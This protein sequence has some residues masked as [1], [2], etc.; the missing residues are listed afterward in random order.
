MNGDT[1]WPPLY[2]PSWTST[3]YGAA[4]QGAIS[5]ASIYQLIL[6]KHCHLA[7]PAGDSRPLMKGPH[8][9]IKF[10]STSENI[11]QL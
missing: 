9:L 11:N 7:V 5:K 1:E 4:T 3:I 8:G 2:A 6:F 10:H